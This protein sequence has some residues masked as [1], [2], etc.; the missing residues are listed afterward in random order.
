MNIFEGTELL[1]E[2]FLIHV[3]CDYATSFLDQLLRRMVPEARCG[4][5]KLLL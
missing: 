3:N 4:A 1:F 5:C 2:C